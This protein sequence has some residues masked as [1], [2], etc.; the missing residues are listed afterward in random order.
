MSTYIH[1]RG[2]EKEEKTNPIRLAVMFPFIIMLGIE[3]YPGSLYPKA[4]WYFNY[5]IENFE[6][7]L[8]NENFL[9]WVGGIVANS[10]GV[11]IQ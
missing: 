4:P 5:E 10:Q 8:L 2:K 1:S 6:T 9:F 7:G 11:W 3:I